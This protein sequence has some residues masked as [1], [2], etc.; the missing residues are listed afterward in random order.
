M[1]NRLSKKEPTMN[2][3]L[4]KMPNIILPIFVVILTSAVSF[5]ADSTA[6]TPITWNAFID[7]YYTKNFNDPSNRINGL[8]NF[9]IYQ[10]QITLG[11]AD[12]TIQKQAQPVGFKVELGFGT[13]NDIVQGGVTSTLSNVIQAYGTLIAPIGSGLTIDVGKFITHMGNEVIVSQNDWNYSRSYLFAFAIPYYH[14]GVRLTYPVASN[15]TAALH[16]VNGWNSN[17]DNN[18]FISVGTTLNYA[19]TPSTSIVF[20]GMW[21]HEN[22]TP[23]ENG[24]RDVYDFVVTQQLSDAFQIAVNADYGQ[25]GTTSGLALWKGLAL[26]GRYQ[27]T[28][29][30]AFVLRG[31]VYYDPVGYTTTGSYSN[32]F[33]NQPTGFPY[34]A[35]YKEV[36]LT[37]ELHPYDPLLIRFEARDDFANGNSFV[38]ASTP[39]AS[40]KSQPTLTVG[41]VTMF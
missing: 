39:L 4:L 3:L 35:T 16:I 22:L 29:V 2:K 19:V 7:A 34:K 10:N 33:T 13:T 28:P 32:Q 9:D 15:F 30:S 36:T 14:T 37:Y 1:I 17:I 24:A 12:L 20:N 11:L 18:K 38:S 31:E 27:L 8:R 26:Y 41:V 21:G 5:A 6:T 25:A 23:I 40:R